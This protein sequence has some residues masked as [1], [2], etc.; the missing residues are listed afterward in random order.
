MKILKDSKYF[1]I[2]VFG[3]LLLA[4]WIANYSGLSGFGLYEDDYWYV[5]NSVNHTTG[6]LFRFV[7]GVL[8]DVQNNEGRFIGKTLPL[9]L[10]HF[11]F[12]AGGFKALFVAGLLLVTTNAWILYS[13]IR[14]NY[15]M[16]IGL[17]AAM[18][19]LVFPTDTT[20]PF[21]THIYQLQLS[22]LF[23]MI[24]F[25]FYDRKH[26]IPAYLFALF[27]LLTYE[28]AFLPFVFAPFLL[29]V[30]WDRK[31]V[32]TAVLH[33]IL[34][35]ILVIGI[36]MMR[37]LG[38]EGRVAALSMTDFAK[39]TLAS[40][41]MGPTAALFAF[42]V[43][44]WEALRS[45]SHNLV[46]ILAGTT[47]A[48]AGLY[49]LVK[50]YV[51]GTERR[52][53][54]KSTGYYRASLDID[55]T[56][57]QFVRLFVVSGAM[58]MVGYLF[59][60]TH[61][62]PSIIKGRMASVH[63][64]TS[65]SG[66][67]FIANIL[68]LLVFLLKKYRIPVLAAIALFLGLQSGYS[69]LIQREYIHGWSGEKQFWEETVSLVKDVDEGTLMLIP[70]EDLD[71]TIFI[72]AHSWAVPLVLPE[73]YRFP[74]AWKYKPKVKKFRSWNEFAY[75]SVKNSVYFTTDYPFMFENRDTVYLEDYKT[76]FLDIENG[77]MTRKTDSLVFDGHTVYLKPVSVSV[78]DS[79][80]LRNLGHVVFSEK[81]E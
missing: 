74:D 66:A 27:S 54:E 23:T 7:G 19:Y 39:K 8:T 12:N 62:P 32:K 31:F 41:I 55:N 25:L 77:V 58:M 60:Y 57:E 3:F 51:P 28:N 50:Q 22:L 29:I 43:S 40:T 70:A 68:Y 18:V 73:S 10:I 71:S 36:F 26:F 49:L 35:G 79:L 2:L 17:L 16:V 76:V 45:V 47:V 33:L 37:K 61:Y 9:V 24:A 15:N 20:R 78:M 75:D 81:K 6:E 53:Y 5:A 59:S 44:S 38:G 52:T 46:A 64:A 42:F 14:K 30:K 69:N 48:F 72:Q 56:L 13:L 67:L 4:N 65:V 80:P 21:L 63:F 11:I 1:G 34:C